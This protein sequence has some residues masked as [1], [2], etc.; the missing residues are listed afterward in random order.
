MS[1]LY[2]ESPATWRAFAGI[3]SAS[4]FHKQTSVR[5]TS[6]EDL[7][8]IGPQ[9]QIKH[10]DISEGDT[11]EWRLGTY[12]K[13]IRVSRQYLINDDIGFIDGIVNSMGP[14]AMRTLANLIYETLQTPGSFFS[15]GNKNLITS[16]PLSVQGFANA[17][18]LM[19]NQQDENGN[20]ID[21]VPTTLV[22]PPALE[23]VAKEILQSD[24]TEQITTLADVDNVRGTGNP[25]KES[26]RLEVEPRL[27]A[28][29]V[30]WYM[31][32]QPEMAPLAVG[33]LDGKQTPTVDFLGLDSD[34]STLG[35]SWR[36]YHDFGAALGDHRACLKSDG[37]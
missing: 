2:R 19:R 9:G 11:Y 25:F 10:D 4:N 16:N 15:N 24:Y 32:A 20:Y 27:S 37:S 17:L 21:T 3:K 36:V 22:V 34:P 6:F 33:F 23:K 29:P 18:E 31:F 26:V 35:V 14:A 5:P 13:M 1:R 30:E 8:E 7:E 28:N 12:A